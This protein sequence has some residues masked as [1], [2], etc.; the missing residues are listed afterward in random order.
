MFCLGRLTRLPFWWPGE[1]P[2]RSQRGSLLDDDP[3]AAARAVEQVPG[4]AADLLVITDFSRVR[5]DAPGQHGQSGNLFVEFTK[6]LAALLNLLPGRR[7]C[8]LVENV[9]MANPA[10]AQWFSKDMQ[11][12]AILVDSMDYG[13]IH[14]PRLWW[15]W[16]AWTSVKAYPGSSSALQWQKGA[17]RT[18]RLCLP[19]PKDS[20]S[21]FQPAGMKFH[22]KVL[23]REVLLPCLTTPATS[24]EGREAPRNLKGKIDSATRARW[25]ERR[26]QFAPWFFKEE[27]L[28]VDQMGRFHLLPASTKERLHH[29]VPDYTAC[30]KISDK[31]RHRLLGNSWHLGVA[32]EVFRFSIMYGVRSLPG[33]HGQGSFDVAGVRDLASAENLARAH[34]LLLQRLPSVID[35]VDMLPSEDMW[36]HW[37]SSARAVHPLLQRPPLEPALEITLQRLLHFDHSRLESFRAQ[38]IR[39]I[40]ARKAEMQGLTRE[41]FQSLPPHVQNAY[42]LPD[43]QIVQIPLFL[44]RYPDADSLEAS[45]GFPVLGKLEHSPGW[46][47]RTDD[48]Y[49]HPIS[50]AAFKSLNQGYVCEKVVSGSSGP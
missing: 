34:P 32:T 5:P 28:L 13:A 21:D 19:V 43:D 1:P 22:Q 17:G 42:T 47:P 2:R 10:D 41:W 48:R 35:H 26:R 31:D 44:S 30:P 3:A 29:Y 7:A 25:L 45:L 23:R 11:A 50:L 49:D 46:R 18:M 16:S 4:G 14:R 27:A 6:F 39:D 40:Q 38:V 36:G 20:V 9:V 33:P 24:D 12:E 15:S 37:E 8:L